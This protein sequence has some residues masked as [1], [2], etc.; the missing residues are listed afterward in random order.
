MNAIRQL[1]PIDANGNVNVVIETPRDSRNKYKFDSEAGIFALSNVLSQG[2][3]FPFVFG[4]IPG[5]M[6]GDGDPLDV[7]VLIEAATF[8]GCLIKARLLG[9]IEAEQESSGGKKRNDRLVAVPV[10]S[11]LHADMKSLDQVTPRLLEEIEH[12]FISYHEMKGEPFKP[13]GRHGPDRAHAL[14]R[15]S[16]D[17]P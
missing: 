13:L 12:Y 4:F 15:E 1:K 5:T 16:I 6:G 9:A 17:S 14:L 7:L 3:V 2:H 10:S 8:P 11:R